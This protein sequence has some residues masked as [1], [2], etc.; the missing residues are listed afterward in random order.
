MGRL[1]TP[2]TDQSTGLVHASI[3]LLMSEV[4]RLSARVSDLVELEGQRTHAMEEI[5]TRLDRIESRVEALEAPPLDGNGNTKTSARSSR[6]G[7]NDTPLL[8]VC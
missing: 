6:G 8:K 5:V 4:Q 2:F 1:D 3:K 7:S